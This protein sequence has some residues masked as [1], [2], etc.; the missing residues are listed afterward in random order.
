[1]GFC[2][3]C[4]AEN[5]DGAKFCKSCGAPL[6]SADSGNQQVA[7]NQM[8][9]SAYA[10]AGRQQAEPK[11]AGNFLQ[12]LKKIPVKV[13][14]GIGA[15]VVAIVVIAVVATK[16]GSTINLNKYLT[17]ETTG[18]D[19]YGR[20]KADIDWEA[21]GKKY[22]SKMSFTSKAKKEYGGLLKMTN[23]AEVL[24]S[25]VTVN[26]DTVDHL[27]NGDEVAYTI[28]IDEELYDYLK[29]T[30]KAK[31]NSFTVKDLTPVGK[32]DAFADLNVTFTGVAPD[33]YMEM[34]YTGSEL[35]SYDF[36]CSER[37]GLSN[38]DT[39]KVTIDDSTIAICAER[40][41]K[42][43]EASEKEYEVKGLSSYVKDLSEISPDALEDMK[44]QAED[45]YNAHVA[46]SWGEGEKLMSFDYLGEYLLT[47]KNGSGYNSLYLVYKAKVHNTA[48]DSHDKVVFDE[49][50]DV[51]WY[52]LYRNIMT[53][54][55]GNMD[56]DVN[57]YD[58]VS[59]TFYVEAETDSW[60]NYKTWY[61]YGYETL[62]ELYKNVV[63]VNIDDYNYQENISEDVAA[64]DTIVQEASGEDLGTDADY[65]LPD[66]D[67]KLLTEEDLD[68]LSADDCKLARNEIYAR[69]GRKF[70]DEEI[71]S[72][73]DSK[74]W[75]EGTVEPDDFKDEYLPEIERKNVQ[76]ISDYEEEKGYK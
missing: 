69:H 31:D 6:Q 72:Y 45:V 56:Y 4:G 40:L 34:E 49:M 2:T 50:T 62:D 1:M 33:G 76:F 42:V 58:T 12:T 18:Y 38:G 8:N 53:D 13:W 16:L 71:Q 44:K 29:C 28:D 70:N 14:A 52:I 5:A 7:G 61:Y 27:T 22:N 54:G 37:S 74:D 60:W 65:I 59:H 25:Y 63:T 35:D 19:G 46:R 23:P 20:A 9:G 51:Y 75:Y 55:E 68:G 11:A 17:V 47:P 15:A 10:N 30:V 67:K 41:G 36:S 73:F 48:E 3:K 57:Y 43:P 64:A 21:V 66:S 32:F 24:S 26:V 39:V